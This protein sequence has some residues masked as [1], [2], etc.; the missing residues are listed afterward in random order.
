MAKKQ[1]QTEEP[2]KH[3]AT[4]SGSIAEFLRDPDDGYAKVQA[5]QRLILTSRDGRS[6]VVIGPGT[7]ADYD[8][9]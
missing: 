9:E 6:R 2:A 8:A 3:S 7:I 5:G 1:S 4:S